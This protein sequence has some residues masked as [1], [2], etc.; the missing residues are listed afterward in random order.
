MTACP[1]LVL[2]LQLLPTLLLQ[3]LTSGISLTFRLRLPFRILARNALLSAVVEEHHL[4]RW[5][6]A[7]RLPLRGHI[8]QTDDKLKNFGTA[9]AARIRIP[10]PEVPTGN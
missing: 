6:D 2:L 9:N 1:L 3:G 5:I 8:T 4:T 10:T 7:F